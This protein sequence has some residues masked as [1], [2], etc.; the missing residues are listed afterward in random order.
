MY[1]LCKLFHEN[2]FKL[3]NMYYLLLVST[4]KIKSFHIFPMYIAHKWKHDKFQLVI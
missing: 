3:V 1:E 2:N 4:L